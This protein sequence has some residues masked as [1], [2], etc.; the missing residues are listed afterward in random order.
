M[1]G[2]PTIYLENCLRSG[3][4]VRDRRC[5]IP[6]FL[7]AFSTQVNLF[8]GNSRPNF[9]TIGSEKGDSSNFSSGAKPIYWIGKQKTI[10]PRQTPASKHQSLE[11]N[12]WENDAFL[13]IS[14]NII[15]F[16]VSHFHFRSTFVPFKVHFRRNILV[17]SKRRIRK[18]PTFSAFLTLC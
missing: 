13:E 2:N 16:N 3:K 15:C 1:S 5:D 7:N 18:K 12:M 6:A 9:Q 17:G 10:G 8:L 11:Q 4:R 14:L